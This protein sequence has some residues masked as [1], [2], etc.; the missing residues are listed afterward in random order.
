MTSHGPGHVILRHQTLNFK[1]EAIPILLTQE[2]LGK[3]LLGTVASPTG[4]LPQGPWPNL[5]PLSL[6]GPIVSSKANDIGKEGVI[7]C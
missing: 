2:F 1:A 5:L 3:I 7:G 6:P 4:T